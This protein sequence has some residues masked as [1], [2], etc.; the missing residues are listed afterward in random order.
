MNS[1]QSQKL[2]V[3]SIVMQYVKA[4]IA[5]ASHPTR[6]LILLYCFMNYIFNFIDRWLTS[7][8]IGSVII[9]KNKRK[10]NKEL[11]MITV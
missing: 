8:T 6:L 2:A 11:I 10:D 3:G 9:V 5:N 4:A 7:L 1:G